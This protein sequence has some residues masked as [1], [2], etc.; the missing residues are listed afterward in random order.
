L[1]FEDVPIINSLAWTP[2]GKEIIFSRGLLGGTG[3]WRVSA[4]GGEPRPYVT[5][6]GC[7]YPVFSPQGERLAFSQLSRKEEIWRLDLSEERGG[8]PSQIKFNP[9]T[10]SDFYA[11]ISGDGRVVFTST[12]SGKRGL[13]IYDN[14][15]ND[16]VTD[17][18]EG[19]L[20]NPNWSS[21]DTRI[22]F[23]TEH[24]GLKYSVSTIRPDGSDLRLVIQE[25]GKRPHWSTDGLWVYFTKDESIW[26]VPSEGGIPVR[27]VDNARYPFEFGEHLYFQRQRAIGRVPREGGPETQILRN[28]EEGWDITDKG[29]YYVDLDTD[30]PEF[31]LYDWNTKQQSLLETAVGFPA[32]GISVA[33]DGQWLLYDVVEFTV[34]IMLVE[35]FR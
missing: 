26:R 16:F 2:D 23:A 22:A 9:S 25:G 13:W 7:L 24:R 28:V 29:I 20:H 35:N 30:P 14:G 31:R 5:E 15:S 12:R 34:D 3:L 17:S 10:G 18:D 21:D 6:P 32:G 11:D 33:S 27:I 4:E 8:K 19:G 1:L